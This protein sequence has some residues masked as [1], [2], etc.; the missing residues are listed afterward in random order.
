M[1]LST[2]GRNTISSTLTRQEEQEQKSLKYYHSIDFLP[3]GCF[4]KVLETGDYRYLLKLD[5]YDELPECSLNLD[6]VWESIVKEYLDYSKGKNKRV[7][8][9]FIMECEV[10]R[11]KAKFLWLNTKLGLIGVDVD[12]REEHIREFNEEFDEKLEYTDT[13]DLKRKLQA[14]SKRTGLIKTE[15]KILEKKLERVVEKDNDKEFKFE[16]IVD[17][18]ET[19]KKF[20]LDIWKISVTRWLAIIENYKEYVKEVEKNAKK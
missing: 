10:V 7:E 17:N 19:Y 5:D 1:R 12:N 18:I 9:A 11:L 20:Y 16:D 14:F 3:V 2:K 8:T 13:D 15:W 6:E 4:Y